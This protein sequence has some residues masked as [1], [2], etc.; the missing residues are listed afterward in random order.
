MLW[1][2]ILFICYIFLE[3]QHIL[4]YTKFAEFNF[5]IFVIYVLY[6]VVGISI[7]INK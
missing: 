2:S 6:R 1:N 4:T 7:V 3:D 5:A